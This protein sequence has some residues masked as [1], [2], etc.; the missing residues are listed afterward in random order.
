[1]RV[2]RARSLQQGSSRTRTD[3]HPHVCASIAWP[4]LQ[5]VNVWCAWSVCVQVW[6]V[7]AAAVATRLGMTPLR[8][9]T[10]GVLNTR[11]GT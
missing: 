2:V 6:A 9:G 4:L 7:P 10:R 3:T 1:M 8:A 5:D 11:L